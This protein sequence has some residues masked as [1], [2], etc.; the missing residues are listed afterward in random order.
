M[1][2]YHDTDIHVIYKPMYTYLRTIRDKYT[3][4]HTM[5][6]N[7]VLGRKYNRDFIQIIMDLIFSFHDTE[8]LRGS[9]QLRITVQK[10]LYLGAIWVNFTPIFPTYQR[11]KKCRYDHKRDWMPMPSTRAH[12]YLREALKWSEPSE[13][14]VLEHAVNATAPDKQLNFP[15]EPPVI[16]GV[17][18]VDI[19]L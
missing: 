17:L 16:G 8:M 19:R 15:H 14:Q 13:R 10:N 11:P 6:K 5:K 3:N 7:T 9:V 18:N 2:A 1:L 4:R 12:R